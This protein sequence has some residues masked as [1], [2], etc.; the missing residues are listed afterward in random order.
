M[1]SS[2][3]NTTNQKLH[4]LMHDETKPSSHNRPHRPPHHP[5]RDPPLPLHSRE[6]CST[7]MVLWY[8]NSGL[9][10]VL[11]R[12]S[13]QVSLLSLFLTANCNFCFCTEGFSPMLLRAIGVCMLHAGVGLMPSAASKE[14]SG[15]QITRT[16]IKI[17]C[18]VTVYGVDEHV[19]ARELEPLRLL[20]TRPKRGGVHCK[21]R[22]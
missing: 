7:V 15:I 5:P 12:Q 22:D 1:L 17:L 3:N 13:H 10:P 14:E 19:A 20:R 16:S 9:Q 6:A 18:L 4:S 2:A 8:T 21:S 11:Q